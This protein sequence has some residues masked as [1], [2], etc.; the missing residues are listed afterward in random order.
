MSSTQ[1]QLPKQL[2]SSADEVETLARVLQSAYSKHI[3]YWP[4]FETWTSYR[5]EGFRAEARTAIAHLRER[6][7]VTVPQGV[8]EIK[9]LR[10]IGINAYLMHEQAKREN[11]G[12]MVG[13]MGAAADAIRAALAPWLREPV[14]WELDVTAQAIRNAWLDAEAGGDSWDA[15][16]AILDLCRS[17][18]RPVFECKECAYKQTRIHQLEGWV[19]ALRERRYRAE[20][21]AGRC[22]SKVGA[23]RCDAALEGE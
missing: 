9:A 11:A 17:R 13:P 3:G 22:A 14:G 20:W 19:G 16:E 12:C 8:P 21:D 4:D 23:V 10:E 6:S 5:Q 2:S 18:I 15:A 7:A 1:D